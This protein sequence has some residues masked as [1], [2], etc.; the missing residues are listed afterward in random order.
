MK[1]EIILGF[2]AAV[3]IVFFLF[4][5]VV[6]ISPA[7]TQVR[8][9]VYQSAPFEWLAEG[10]YNGTVPYS[11]V[12]KYGDTGLGTFDRLDGEMVMVEGVAYRVAYD[13]TVHIVDGDMTTPFAEVTIF[14]RD[15]SYQPER[16]MNYSQVRDFIAQKTAPGETIST[17]RLDGRFSGVLTRSVPAQNSPYKPLNDVIPAEQNVFPGD[18]VNGTAVGFYHPGYM[19]GANAEGFHLHFI[20]DERNY[21]GHLLDFT[22][23]SGVISIDLE[24]SFTMMI[25]WENF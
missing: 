14:D 6:S 4:A 13:G 17:I 8:D 22:M 7:D 10:K 2:A 5:A 11:E 1:K 18:D 15:V 9:T 24:D 20:N 19:N 3:A 12:L 16:P 23:E 25:P 21:G